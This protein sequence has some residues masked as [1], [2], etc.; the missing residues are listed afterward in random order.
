MPFS[1]AKHST[2]AGET[3]STPVGSANTQEP[4]PKTPLPK[5]FQLHFDPMKGT[6]VS[7]PSK[8]VNDVAESS[9]EFHFL[10]RNRTIASI[11]STE[12]EESFKKPLA[13][14]VSS[15]RPGVP[16]LF[17]KPNHR[18]EV[19]GISQISL[20]SDSGSPKLFSKPLFSKRDSSPPHNQELKKTRYEDTFFGKTISKNDSRNTESVSSTAS[21]CKSRMSIGLEI[22]N[23]V[24]QLERDHLNDIEKVKEALSSITRKY[25]DQQEL[26]K[27]FEKASFVLAE[28]LE[29]HK[30]LLRVS[31]MK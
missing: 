11:L 2:K 26:N 10:K 16:S 1:F 24:E 17:K 29:I 15:M 4:T 19:E 20:P 12:N 9:P 8:S 3:P 28:S 21:S 18:E 25:K 5:P 22:Q 14:E 27:R 7:T 23:M 31:E 13:R 30:Y 6:S